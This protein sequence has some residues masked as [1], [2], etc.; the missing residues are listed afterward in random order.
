[1]IPATTFANAAAEKQGTIL[2]RLRTY[3]VV[4]ALPGRLG[5][6]REL[7]YNLW[8]SWNADAMELFRRLNPDLWEDMGQNPVKF[9]A[10][11]A[12][13]RLDQ[14]A[15]DKAYLAHMDRVL[16]AFDEYA[17][18]E[19]IVLLDDDLDPAAVLAEL[20]AQEMPAPSWAEVERRVVTWS[21]AR[22]GGAAGLC[23]D[24][25]QCESSG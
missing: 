7:A 25:R 2:Y 3:T 11:L 10:H 18:V 12:Q 1:M 13:R 16:E 24:A 15:S 8:W 5:R 19:R 9:L 20:R 22:H 14:A 6:L 23:R 4:P 17:Q 21:Q